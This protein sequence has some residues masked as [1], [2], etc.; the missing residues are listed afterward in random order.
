MNIQGLKVNMV[1]SDIHLSDSLLSLQNVNASSREETV[2]DD[3]CIGLMSR[4]LL[5]LLTGH[6][7][8]GCHQPTDIHIC[9][10]YP[11]CAVY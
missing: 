6:S 2:N 4:C 5:L 3:L 7:S 11:I 8:F 9:H 10:K 1:F